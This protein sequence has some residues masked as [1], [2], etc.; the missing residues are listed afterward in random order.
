MFS[1]WLNFRLNQSCWHKYFR[2]RYT[3]LFSQKYFFG[4]VLFYLVIGIWNNMLHRKL[5]KF[6]STGCLFYKFVVNNLNSS[7]KRRSKSLKCI[8]RR[9]MNFKKSRWSAKNA[10]SSFFI[11]MSSNWIQPK[12][13]LFWKSEPNAS[14][15]F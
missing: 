12:L 11:N 4:F 15:L 8:W 1:S 3:S 2:F 9:A 14:I 13:L 5:E 10:Y 6:S 7:Q